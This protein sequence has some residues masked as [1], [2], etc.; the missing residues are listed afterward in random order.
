MSV[1]E[2]VHVQCVRC[3]ARVGTCATVCLL[4]SED[5]LWVSLLC[6]PHVGPRVDYLWRAIHGDPAGADI[7]ALSPSC[8]AVILGTV[9]VT[10]PQRDLSRSVLLWCY[11]PGLLS[12]VLHSHW[13]LCT[14]ATSRPPATEVPTDLELSEV[15]SGAYSGPCVCPSILPLCRHGL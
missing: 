2:G 14:S 15:K 6:F 11:C 9:L 7:E 5:N 3:V 8:V 4:K 10:R 1:H 13:L 12:S